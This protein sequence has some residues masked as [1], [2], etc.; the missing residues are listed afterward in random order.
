MTA[1]SVG[2]RLAQLRRRMHVVAAVMGR[3]IVW[4]IGLSL[5]G[6]S[7]A[8]PAI[9]GCGDHVIHPTLL[10]QVTDW[11]HSSWLHNIQSPLES[12]LDPG[13][14]GPCPGPGCSHGPEQPLEAVLPLLSVDESKPHA[15]ADLHMS[16]T[17]AERVAAAVIFNLSKLPQGLSP[18]IFH[19][20]RSA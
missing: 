7:S 10:P 11:S 20:P 8:S 4:I 1:T 6:W 18:D 16:W 19:P 15:L 5:W 14:P 12:P 2:V 13:V 9:A 17:E 3:S